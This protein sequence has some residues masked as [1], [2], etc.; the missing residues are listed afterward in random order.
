M[1]ATDAPT[2]ER[3][4]PSIEVG[5]LREA[6]TFLTD[7]VGFPLIMSEGEPPMFAI[8]GTDHAEI[9]LVE[10]DEPALPGGAACYVTLQG[11]DALIGRIGAAGIELAIPLTERPWGQRDIV[12]ALPG[13]GPMIAFGERTG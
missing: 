6:L 4:R 7:V 13:E 1:T 11:L 8:V 3:S 9:A 10:V 5:D 2:F 12:V